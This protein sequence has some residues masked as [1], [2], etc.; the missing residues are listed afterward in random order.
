M[1]QTAV[2]PAAITAVR[3]VLKGAEHCPSSL[4]TAGFQLGTRVLQG[5]KRS[6]ATAVRRALGL[7]QFRTAC[8]DRQGRQSHLFV[9]MTSLQRPARLTRNASEVLQCAATQRLLSDYERRL[10]AGHVQLPPPLLD[11][12]PVLCP[13]TRLRTS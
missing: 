8:A 13:G 11:T 2:R 5:I 1:R 9:D 10:Q 12:D 3:H 4:Q 6:P 7:D